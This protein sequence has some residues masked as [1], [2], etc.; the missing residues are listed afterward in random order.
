MGTDREVGRE[1]GDVDAYI[2]GMRARY[3]RKP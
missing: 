2:A 1:V 3:E